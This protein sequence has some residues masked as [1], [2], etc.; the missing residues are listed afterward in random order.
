[1]QERYALAPVYL[2]V[3]G[4]GVVVA[5]HHLITSALC[6]GGNARTAYGDPRNAV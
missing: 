4:T 5:V 3:V 6:D 1:M 2:G